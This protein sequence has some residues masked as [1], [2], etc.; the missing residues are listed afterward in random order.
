MSN[1]DNSADVILRA[2]MTYEGVTFEEATQLYGER[3]NLPLQ[4][5]CGP[6]MTFPTHDKTQTRRAIILLNR[7]RPHGWQK[8]LRCVYVRARQFGMTTEFTETKKLEWYVKKMRK[9][10]KKDESKKEE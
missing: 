4:A 1:S 6:N 2:M 10:D 3:V 7:L 5:F 9:V 8:I